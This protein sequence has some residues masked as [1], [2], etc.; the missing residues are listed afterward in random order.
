MEEKKEFDSVTFDQI[1]T[2][3]DV[4]KLR[5]L[6]QYMRDEGFTSTADAAR[7]RLHEMGSRTFTDDEEVA[8]REAEVE[9]SKAREELSSWKAELGALRQKKG[10]RRANQEVPT[11]RDGVA[12]KAGGASITEVVEERFD[13]GE[14]EFMP[15][16][17]RK[18]ETSSSRP[19]STRRVSR[20]TTSPFLWHPRLRPW[21]T[22]P[23]R[24]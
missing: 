12:G 6:E 4:S 13:A 7:V 1:Q 21:P 24:S 9:L 16:G 20:P 5:R 11:V 18:R 8:K 19:G 23:L 10:A 22:A 17:R 3:S 14:V 2:I 15:R